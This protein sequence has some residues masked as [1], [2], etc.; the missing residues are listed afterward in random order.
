MTKKKILI[1]IPSYGFD[2]TEAAVPWKLLSENG[3][4]ITFATPKG[5]KAEGDKIMLTGEGLGP[6][7]KILK[8]R[9]DAVFAYDLMFKSPEFSNPISYSEIDESEFDSIYLPGGHDKGVREYLESDILQKVIPLFFESGKKVGAIC[10]GVI[11]LA[12]SKN[13]GNSKSVIY[14]YKTTSLLKSQELLAYNLTKLWLKDYYLTYPGT[15]VEDEVTGVLKNKS[16]FQYGPK[17][18]FRDSLKNTKPGFV[19]IDRNY[20]SARWPGDIYSFTLSYIELLN[21]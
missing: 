1:P 11:L 19:T 13:M 18:I 15:T 5:A 2:P 7:K 17:P 8:A 12:R 3:F 9:K 16:Q 14:D 6:F 20:I 21:E 10:H 4:S